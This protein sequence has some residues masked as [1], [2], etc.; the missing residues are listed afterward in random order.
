MELKPTYNGKGEKR[1]YYIGED[2][3]EYFMYQDERTG[4]II[5][6][7]NKDDII[8]LFNAIKSQ[9]VKKLS[10]M[11]KA[12][13]LAKVKQ[14]VE[15][16]L[17]ESEEKTMLV[18]NTKNEIIAQLDFTENEPAKANLQI[19]VRDQRTLKVKGR[20]IMELTMKMVNSEK[21][22]DEVWMENFRL[23]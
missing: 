10:P 9:E 17:G 8:P 2:G 3:K 18:L 14:K 1:P 7:I 21:V 23:V 5:R 12:V 16:M 6:E 11:N 4:Y 20:K 22:Y 19:Y 15:E 13:Y